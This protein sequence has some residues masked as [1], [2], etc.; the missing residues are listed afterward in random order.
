MVECICSIACR[1]NAS[2]QAFCEA[3]VAKFCEKIVFYISKWLKIS[4]TFAFVAQVSSV[5]LTQN[6]RYWQ[7]SLFIHL[8]H[9][10]ALPNF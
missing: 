7:K 2:F 1:L 10:F 9:L 8:N 4:F 5:N 3:D 6:D